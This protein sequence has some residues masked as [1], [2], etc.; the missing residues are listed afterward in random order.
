[1]QI[2]TCRWSV[3]E[4]FGCVLGALEG[5]KGVSPLFRLNVQ[6]C[7]HET[8]ILRPTERTEKGK[9]SMFLSY[10]G[11]VDNRLNLQKSA[12]FLYTDKHRMCNLGHNSD[13]IKK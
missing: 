9:A 8:A 5:D 2:T 11:I 12:V 1:M 7:Q 4:V 3:L 13:R 6:K 10:I